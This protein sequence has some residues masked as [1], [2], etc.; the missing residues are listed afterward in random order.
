MNYF[1]II[2]SLYHLHKMMFLIILSIAII[3][4]TIYRSTKVI[5]MTGLVVFVLCT[6]ICMYYTSQVTVHVFFGEVG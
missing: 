5:I 6:L 3:L 4:E 1:A 2:L